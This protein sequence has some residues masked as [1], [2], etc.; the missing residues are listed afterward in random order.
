MSD[1]SA[2]E[3]YSIVTN[4]YK[5]PKYFDF[6]EASSARASVGEAHMF[7]SVKILFKL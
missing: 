7:K 1:I 2:P 6:P 3:M 4:V 5:T